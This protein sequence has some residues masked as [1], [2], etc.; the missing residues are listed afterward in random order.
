MLSQPLK[1]MTPKRADSWFRRD[2]QSGSDPSSAF[3]LHWSWKHNWRFGAL[4]HSENWQCRF[5]DELRRI[6]PSWGALMRKE[7][8]QIEFGCFH[9]KQLV[10]KSRKTD[11]NTK[12][13][14]VP[15]QS[16]NFWFTGILDRAKKP[17]FHTHT[18]FHF[19]CVPIISWYLECDWPLTR[20]VV[21]W[22]T[23]QKA[24]WSSG[25]Y[26]RAR[27]PRAHKI[28]TFL[29]EMYMGLAP[30]GLSFIYPS[31]SGHIT[32]FCISR[33]R[34]RTS[35]HGPRSKNHKF[36]FNFPPFWY[37]WWFWNSWVGGTW[38][39]WASQ[40][41][42]RV[43]QGSPKKTA[44]TIHN[45]RRCASL[46]KQ[47]PLT[48]SVS[49]R[50]GEQ[51]WCNFMEKQ[52]KGLLAKRG[53]QPLNPFFWKLCR[54]GKSSRSDNVAAECRV[55]CA[56]AEEIIAVNPLNQF[57][58]LRV[59]IKLFLTKHYQACQNWEKKR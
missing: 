56:K 53:T 17:N 23:C 6:F 21:S 5:Y 47:R 58:F 45:L 7:V 36:T 27:C 55:L 48:G 12:S 59:F 30:P 22:N 49:I 37:F 33:H 32:L 26:L 16:S 51:T 46:W 39:S 1:E 2:S 24:D 44:Q 54:A 9:G 40:R 35:V 34:S 20:K 29:K 13:A 28:F 4:T 57:G 50:T 14:N 31:S 38:I 42:P 10:S 41:P 18:R 3:S 19:C 43:S 8:N 15:W 11:A 52:K 25:V